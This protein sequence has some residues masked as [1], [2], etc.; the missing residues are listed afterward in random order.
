MRARSA[1]RRALNLTLLAAAAIAATL[2][3]P[4]DGVAQTTRVT[5]GLVAYYPFSE[6]TG[7]RVFDRKLN[8]PYTDL[9]FEGDVVW[10]GT[11]NGVSFN[12]GR[13]GTLVEATDLVDALQATNQ[14]S[15]E[16]WVSPAN[17]TQDGPA[18]MLALGTGPSGGAHDYALGQID[19]N[20]EVRL[21]HTGKTGFDPRIRTSDG[22][23]TTGLVHLVH[24]FDGATERLY[25]DGV[26]H[27]A[28]VTSP[29]NLSSWS[30]LDLLS[31]GNTSTRDRSWRGVVRSVA[32]YDQALSAAEVAQNFQFGPDV[33]L[34]AD[35]PLTVD[36]G[37]DQVTSSAPGRPLLSTLLNGSVDD[38]DGTGTF[39]SQW[40]LISG[41]QPVVFGDATSPQTT[42]DLP[43]TGVYV[44]EL[45]AS[46]AL[47][48]LA[49]L[50]TVTA[51]SQSSG[52][53]SQ[54]L[55]PPDQSF[56]VS[57]TPT[58]EVDCPPLAP[59]SG[60]F[61]IAEDPTFLSIVYDSGLSPTEVC[62]HV[63]FASLNDLTEYHW[64]ARQQDSAGLWSEWSVPTRFTTGRAGDF[65]TLS[66]QDGVDG[67]LGT[68]DA[69]IRGD[70]QNPQNAIFEW[71]Q[72][73]QDVLRTGRRPP[74]NQDEI[75]R[76]LLRFELSGID[77]DSIANA[78]LELTGWTHGDPSVFFH[79]ATTFFEVR[80]PWGEGAGL[81][82]AAPAPGEASW[83]YAE[84]PLPWSVP[85]ASDPGI[86]R[87]STPLIRA[88][89]T[90]QIG[91]KAV[92]SSQAF[93]ELVRQWAEQPQ[94]NFGVL[95]Q[96]EDEAAQPV[97]KLSGRENSDPSFRPRLVIQLAAVQ[98][99][100]ISADCEDGNACTA[101]VCNAGVCTHAPLAAG[102]S[103]ADGDV[104]NGD[105][106]CDAAGTC[107][108]GSA[109]V[110]DDANSCTIDSCDP[111]NGCMVAP[112]PAGSSCEDVEICNG[113]EV[114]DGA[115]ACLAGVPLASGT[116][117]AD[118][119]VCNGNETCNSSG[120]CV[121]G[122]ALTCNDGD[123]C[124]VDSCD[125]LGGC[126]TVPLT[127]D[128]GNGCT[129]DSCSPLDGCMNGLGELV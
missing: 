38:P 32:I 95:F 67:Y 92:V 25:V 103:C 94:T 87:G 64:S 125:P 120:T 62:S 34:G 43:T 51:P 73:A 115:G 59:D 4:S 114:C 18:R 48:E 35:I 86:D 83:T 113:A 49:D 99:C 40:S 70:F 2:A 85:G 6:G 41:P 60:Q 8:A 107:Q 108:L 79:G 68:S 23:L 84:F 57:P 119:D 100:S 30:D 20:V 39:P 97:L 37:P 75:F 28:T 74:G 56:G 15:F 54:N 91:A 26:E 5:D 93:V 1:L 124:T 50:V 61:L 77:P 122:T 126:M 66:Y 44:F 111:L 11:A 3:L 118:G 90:N 81:A 7:S 128:D 24:V 55:F 82:G 127:C 17:T 112:E 96:A 123:A 12:D 121:V 117:C 21:R 98:S 110:C 116:S 31:I 65:V 29:G 9:T 10:L 33:P 102:D 52:S 36:A 88:R 106:T 58:L 78:Y 69:D 109:P 105:E 13:I 72:G 19:R 22:F 42:V 14:A 16:V 53:P 27:P 46:D 101:D 63:V 89:L 80:I 129:V 45:R 104:C 76:S 71:N 47:R